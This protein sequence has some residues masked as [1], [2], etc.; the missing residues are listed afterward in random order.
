MKIGEATEALD[1]SADTL[2]YYERIKL[3]PKVGRST[4]GVRHYSESDLSRIRYIQQSQK[5]GFSLNEISELLRFR[6]SPA[7]AR[8][9]VRALAV[10]KLQKIEDHLRELKALRQEFKALIAQCTESEGQCPIINHLEK[11]QS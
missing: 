10:A 11:V 3:L 4:G 9:Q 2:R 7:A 6:E 8:P 1:I 5:M